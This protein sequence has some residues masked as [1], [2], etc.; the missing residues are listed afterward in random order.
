MDCVDFVAFSLVYRTAL[1]TRD[2]RWFD[3]CTRYALPAFSAFYAFFYTPHADCGFPLCGYPVGYTRLVALRLRTDYTV[4]RTHVP[5]YVTVALVYVGLRVWIGLF[6]AVVRGCLPHS[7]TLRW[8]A[9]LFRLVVVAHLRL[10][11]T[12]TPR[13]HARFYTLVI[14]VWLPFPHP[15]HGCYVA[16]LHVICSSFELRYTVRLPVYVY[17]TRCVRCTRSL[18]YP[19]GTAFAF[20]LRLPSYFAVTVCRVTFALRLRVCC[21]GC[22]TRFVTLGCCRIAVVPVRVT[23]YTLLITLGARYHLPDALID[24]AGDV[25]HV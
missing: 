20:T 19:G 6:V 4:T 7:Y 2:L 22:Y 13:L 3:C 21:V 24:Y 17:R 9:P 23:D 16:L 25:G 11:Y 14:Y 1:I 18:V 5:G 15:A 10:R 8:F 12:H